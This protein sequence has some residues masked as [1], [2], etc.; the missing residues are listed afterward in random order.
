MENVSFRK[1]RKTRSYS[2]IDPEDT[3]FIGEYDGSMGYQSDHI[4][5]R[6]EFIRRGYDNDVTILYVSTYNS[7]YANGMRSSIR[8]ENNSLVPEEEKIM[9]GGSQTPKIILIND[10]K[11]KKKVFIG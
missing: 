9:P 3:Y 2:L 5:I 1:P 7:G 4:K 11:S 8:G 6:E 10:T